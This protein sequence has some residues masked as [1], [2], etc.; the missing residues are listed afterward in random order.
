MT[1]LRF[2]LSVLWRI[3]EWDSILFVVAV[4]AGVVSESGG[5]A[6]SR[7]VGFRY[8]SNALDLCDD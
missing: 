8:T 4:A 7:G 6:E 2:L 5:E 1:S 3:R